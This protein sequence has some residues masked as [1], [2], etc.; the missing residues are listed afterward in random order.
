MRQYAI[1]HNLPM[2]ISYEKIYKLLRYCITGGL[3]AVF[4]RENIAGK[5]HINEITYDDQ[6]N[7][8]ISQ[9]NENV[10]TRVFALDDNSLYLSSYSSVKNENI[11]QTDHRMYMAGRS[12]FYSEKPYVIKY[13]IDQRK[14]MFVAKVKG[15]F[16][17][18]EYNNLLPLPP[19]FRN[20]EIENKEEVIWEYMYSQ[21][22]KH[23]LLMSKNDRKLTTLLDTNGQFM[24]FN[25][26]YLWLLID[27][28]FIITD[29]KSVAV[30]E[31]NAA[32][33][34]FIRTMMNLRIQAIL[35]ESSKE[36][37]YKLINNASYGYDTLNTEKFGK[38]KMLDKADTFIAQHH[39]NHIGTRRIRANTFAVQIKPKTAICFTSIQSGVLILDNAKFWNLNYIY[40][41]MYKYL[42]RK[43]FR[44]VLADTDSIYIAIEGNPDKDC[45]QQFELIVTDKQFYD[46]HIYQYLPD[47]NKDIYDY[48]K[49]LGFGIKNEG[50]ELTSLGPKCYSTI[51]LKRS[52]GR[53][54]YEFKPKITS[55]GISKSQQI[56]HS[57]Y[58]N[59]INKDIV[60]KCIN[61]TFKMY[62]NVMS[63]IQVEEYAL[64]GFNKKSIVLRNQCCCPYIKGLTANDYIIK[65]Q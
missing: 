54:Q 18:S 65:D 63:S 59:V 48:K 11:P 50:Y 26:Y 62:D 22:Q 55:K 9:D 36:K 29:Y 8:V 40:N 12:R 45:H 33:E 16:P 21:V 20:N 4:H 15:Y 7:K 41:F 1:K 57:D 44:F 58:V 5:T 61:G 56:S 10:V 37:F 19:I 13:C 32:Y 51:V 53:Q 27:L 46:Q 43:R 24:V 52:K 39:P 60:K 35:A 25:N 31:K 23:S 3:A 38:I 6:S 30:F 49:I 2:T 47:P 28:V 14:D 17:K 64:T 42:D 34:P